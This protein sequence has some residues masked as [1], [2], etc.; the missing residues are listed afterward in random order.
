[1]GPSRQFGDVEGEGHP[2]RRRAHL[3]HL[4]RRPRR[5]GGK[6]KSRGGGLNETFEKHRTLHKFWHRPA[7]SVY[8]KQ[9]ALRFAVQTYFSQINGHITYKHARDFPTY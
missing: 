3:H 6:G 8:S 9:V 1:M 5:R 4:L 2:C 7:H